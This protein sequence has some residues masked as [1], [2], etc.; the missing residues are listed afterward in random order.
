VRTA[1]LLSPGAAVTDAVP[2]DPLA[3]VAVEIREQ[4]TVLGFEVEELDTPRAA[5]ALPTFL[6]RLRMATSKRAELVLVDRRVV[7]H[8]AALR[9]LTHDGR[10]GDAL[11][12]GEL[13]DVGGHRAVQ[14]DRGTVVG[15]SS[16]LHEPLSSRASSVGVCRLAD[17]TERLADGVAELARR[18]STGAV[19]AALD[20]APV[21]TIAAAVAVA[22]TRFAAVDRRGMVAERADDA[23][24]ALAARDR[25][26]QIDEDRAWLDAAVKAR[27]GWFTTFLVS[28][29]SRFWARWAA[30][31]GWTPN[32]VSTAAMLLGALAA[33]LFAWGTWP[34]AIA[35][36][37]TLQLSFALDC[38]DGQLSR[39]TQRF[40]RFGAWLDSTFDRAKEYLVYAGLAAWGARTG[41]N[42]IWGLAAGAV[43]LQ[44]VRHTIDLSFS[45]HRPPPVPA[46]PQL[47]GSGTGEALD[48]RG[49]RVLAAAGLAEERPL[50]KWGKRIIVFP[51]GER[52]A[53]ISI[54]A[55]LG[56]PRLTFLLLLA[57]GSLAALYTLTGRL[58][59]SRRWSAAR[60]RW[61][62]LPAARAIEYL[63]V[64]LTGVVVAG[65]GPATYAALAA[66]VTRHYDEVYRERALG[67]PALDTFARTVL[68]RWPVRVGVIV[69]AAVA[70]V[71]EIVLWV[72]AV[73]VASVTLLDAIGSWRQAG[74]GD[75]ADAAGP[76]EEEGAE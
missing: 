75:G 62:G 49:S 51:I 31:H 13:G 10:L 67:R 18:T 45:S 27:D 14:V 59:R 46:R 5:D 39:Y 21:E 12:V 22:G 48:D 15:L 70:G 33:L 36:A 8:T 58:L 1:L 26:D 72:V 7:A 9:A 44:T 37:L 43:A 73:G 56:L 29:Y 2:P 23:T 32:Q 52:F 64:L 20:T 25:R 24:E 69:T 4:L 42:T 57:W 11:L 3:R 60:T 40:T 74:I 68:A 61:L 28:P 76:D 34:S 16:P 55:I 65:A 6:E 66:L 30:R 35:G 71:T 63:V 54:T 41:D 50:L 17:G 47:R 19:V 38:V 53:L